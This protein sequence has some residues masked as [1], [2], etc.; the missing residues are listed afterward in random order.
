MLLLEGRFCGIYE[1]WATLE[2]AERTNREIMTTA[3]TTFCF[4]V[5][6]FLVSRRMT[7]STTK[8][9]MT[10][11]SNRPRDR[12]FSSDDAAKYVSVFIPYSV[13]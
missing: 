10:G 5:S 6:G 7:P 12:A 2:M 8:Y 9:R 4:V 1:F 3:V 11:A 13:P